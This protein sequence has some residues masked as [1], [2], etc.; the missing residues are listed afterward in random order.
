MIDGYIIQE[1]LE[2]SVCRG[3]IISPGIGNGRTYLILDEAKYESVIGDVS[4]KF[5]SGSI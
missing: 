2:M 4:C 3:I 1:T 5:Q